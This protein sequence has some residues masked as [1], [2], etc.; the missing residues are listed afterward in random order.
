MRN[1]LKTICIFIALSM[2]CLV[3]VEGLPA[4][5]AK[6]KRRSRAGREMTGKQERVANGEWGGQHM[7]IQVADNGATLEFPCASGQI[8][9]PL[10]LDGNNRFDV[11]G[12]YEIEGVGPARLGEDNRRQARYTG[13]V[14]GQQMTLTIKL[15]ASGETLGPF[16][17]KL[18]ALTRIVKCG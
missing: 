5:G 1:Y 12:V 17:F 9:E 13:K 15:S 10:A 7:R 4:Q 8:T 16:T 14:N 6:A 3:S 18:G 11:A 2:A